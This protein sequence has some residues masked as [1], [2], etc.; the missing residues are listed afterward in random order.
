MKDIEQ[1]GHRI[2]VLQHLKRLCHGVKSDPGVGALLRRKEGVQII[3]LRPEDLE[4]FAPLSL[5]AAGPHLG[6][7][8]DLR[9][10]GDPFERT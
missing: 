2:P 8:D 6:A 3:P 9:L 1:V 10:D 5:Q 7:V 4:D